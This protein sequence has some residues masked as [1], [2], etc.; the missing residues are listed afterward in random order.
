MATG[1]AKAL[2]PRKQR[3]IDALLKAAEKVFARRPVEE[4]TVEEI[5]E[6]A[7]VA[8]GSIYNNF[9]SKAGL[10]AAVVDRA[11]DVDREYMDRAYT[12][13]RSPIE[14]LEA[15]AEQ[16]LRFYLEQPEFF[17][18]LAFPAPLGGYSAAAETAA[19]LARR[20]DEQN[21]RMIDALERGI[22]DGTIRPVDARK[23]AKVLWSGW[24]G[25]ISLA[26]RPDELR[27]DER[28]LAELLSLAGNLVSWGL[29]RV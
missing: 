26:W 20:V 4:V 10:H 1:D 3:T 7:G 25:V 11:L 12:P 29:R 5:A 22:A 21:A 15:A 19:R 6:R 14:Q 16:Y 17:R 8:V 27:E 28:G 2:D 13:D 23:A 9:G 18:M 24:N